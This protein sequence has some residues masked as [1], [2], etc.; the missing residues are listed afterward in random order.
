MHYVSLE[1]AARM[2][3][4]SIYY[5]ERGHPAGWSDDLGIMAPDNVWLDAEYAGWHAAFHGF[6]QFDRDTLIDEFIDYCN[7]QNIHYMYSGKK[8]LLLEEDS[9]P[10]LLLRYPQ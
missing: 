6:S 5:V 3:K 10:L 9:I 7:S 2:S 8:L 4:I 1:M